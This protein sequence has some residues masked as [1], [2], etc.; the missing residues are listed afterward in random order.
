MNKRFHD[1]LVHADRG[2]EHTGADIRDIGEL[3]Q[4]LNG[5]VFSV[6]TMQHGKHD[7]QPDA[8]H[9]RGAARIDLGLRRTPLDG[10][11]SVLAGMRHEVCFAARASGACRFETHMFDDVRR[12][13]CGWRLVGERPAA[14]LLDADRHRFIPAPVEIL[15]DR[16]G[17]GHRH[18]VLA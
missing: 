6:R 1:R 16:C 12:R 17:R 18:L 9:R 5:A 8:G 11:H 15:D 14:V 3:E 4:P 2:A 10:E 7:I 13:N